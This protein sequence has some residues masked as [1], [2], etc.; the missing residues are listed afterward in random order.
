[1]YYTLNPFFL[2]YQKSGKILA[3]LSRSSLSRGYGAVAYMKQIIAVRAVQRKIFLDG[4]VANLVQIILI[5]VG[6]VDGY[7]WILAL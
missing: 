6:R 4:K 2:Q 1:M 3:G 7:L 5:R